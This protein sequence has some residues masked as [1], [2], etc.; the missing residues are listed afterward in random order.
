[1][2]GR[3]VLIF[4]YTGTAFPVLLSGVRDNLGRKPEKSH[5]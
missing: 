3:L 2:Q 1:M 5:I 4:W